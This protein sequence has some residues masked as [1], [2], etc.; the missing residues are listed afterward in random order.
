MRVVLSADDNYARHLTATIE[1]TIA[2]SKSKLDFVILYT[3]LDE[4]TRSIIINHF[5]NRV[6]SMQCIQ[7]SSEALATIPLPDKN[8]YFSISTYLRVFAPIVL[9]EDDMILYLDSDMIVRDDITHLMEAPSRM[10]LEYPVYAVEEIYHHIKGFE[11]YHMKIVGS[12]TIPL[13]NAGLLIMNLQY[14]RCTNLLD[15]ILH[16]IGSS[17]EPFAF[18]D[19]DALNMVIK[20]N[21]GVLP[22][23][24]NM[25]DT[26][27]NP[28][29]L[30]ES[31]CYTRNEILT[32]IS[33]PS[34]IHY[35]WIYKPWKYL[36]RHPYKEEY[37]KY[38]YLTPWKIREEEGKTY[39]NVIKKNS[40][41]WLKIIVSNM[42][43]LID[44]IF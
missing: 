41:S 16:S 12:N 3:T 36:C 11:N 35:T 13:F 1:S 27:F 23:K 8:S 31:K 43:R 14:W 34:L 15:K 40:P 5:Y 32:A 42:A 39:L 20:G 9:P 25:G 30:G 37:W 2:N 7:V 26:Q 24:W 29:F 44:E 4:S 18:V 10:A 22:V 19:Q 28:I 6:N 38:R 33:N 21:F 17:S